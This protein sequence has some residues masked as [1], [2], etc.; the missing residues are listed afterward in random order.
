MKE[1]GSNQ[2][3]KK[4]EKIA[5]FQYYLYISLLNIVSLGP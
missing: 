3:Y 5:F 4:A 1:D 2:L